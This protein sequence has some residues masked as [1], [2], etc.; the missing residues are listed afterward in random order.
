MNKKRGAA[1]VALTRALD[2]AR[3]QLENLREEEQEAMDALP[4]SFQQGDQGQAMQEGLDNLEGAI[5]DL[6]SA[7]T[8][9]ET[10][11]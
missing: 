11:E 2:D 1:I 8:S 4:D 3:A 5:S 9:L 7:V 10:I 6:E